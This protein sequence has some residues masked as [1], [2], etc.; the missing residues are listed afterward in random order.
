MRY[1][2]SVSDVNQE[3]LFCVLITQCVDTTWNEKGQN[4][5]MK[6]PTLPVLLGGEMNKALESSKSSAFM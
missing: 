2:W 4:S 3:L 1:Q 5:P 6:L